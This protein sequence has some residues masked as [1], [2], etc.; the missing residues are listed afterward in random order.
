MN[1]VIFDLETTGWSPQY[2]EIIQVAAVRMRQG[3]VLESET[4]ETFV[5]PTGGIPPAISAL[6]GITA[7]DVRTAPGPTSA[8]ADFSRFVGNDTI[9]AHNGQ[10]FDLRFIRAHCEGNQISMREV[11]FFD[12]LALSS[13][14]WANEQRHNLDAV[15]E[16]LH[17]SCE[18]RRRHNACDDVFLLAEAVREMWV[19]LNVPF[20]QCPVPLG[21]GHLPA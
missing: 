16:R 8:L 2:S 9:V 3:V 15:M 14:I 7:E 19:R 12:S 17:L 20:D 6:T 5:R 1:L 4:F 21:S 11:P 13:L 10:R 18:G